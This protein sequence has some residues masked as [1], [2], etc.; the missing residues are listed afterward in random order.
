MEFVASSTKVLTV[1][2]VFD[3]LVVGPGFFFIPREGFCF[4][5]ASP[6]IEAKIRGPMPKRFGMVKDTFG[7]CG[8]C[9]PLNLAFNV[10]T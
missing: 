9:V 10:V 5:A 8:W 2:P 4:A 1:V 6:D 7:G 3:S